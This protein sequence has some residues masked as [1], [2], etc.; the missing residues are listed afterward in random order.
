MVYGRC[1]DTI[2]PSEPLS[3]SS[4]KHRLFFLGIGGILGIFLEYAVLSACHPAVSIALG[5]GLLAVAAAL[6]TNMPDQ[7]GR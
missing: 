1:M 5:L 2:E 7:Q 4:A 6:P 3:P